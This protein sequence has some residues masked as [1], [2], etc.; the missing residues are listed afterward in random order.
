MIEY[1][2]SKP[3]RKHTKEIIVFILVAFIAVAMIFYYETIF[4]LLDIGSLS[5]EQ[6]AAEFS[7]WCN[8]CLSAN[9]EIFDYWTVP[10][11]KIGKKLADCSN[12][13]F[14][15]NL[16]PDQDCRGDIAVDCIK[17]IQ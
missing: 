17:Y 9:N 12:E 11:N 14:N 5:E 8:D 3:K 6:C 2:Y 7:E 13:Y 10:G 15:T 4:S 16:S 1:V